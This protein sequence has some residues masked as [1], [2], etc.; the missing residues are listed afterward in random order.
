MAF[1]G[2]RRTLAVLP[3]LLGCGRAVSPGDEAR[4]ER[5]RDGAAV[6]GSLSQL[7]QAEW[8]EA[9]ARLAYLRRGQPARSYVERIRLTLRDPRSGQALQARGAVAVSPG[10]A[11]RMILLGPGGTTA[12]DM[13]VT[14]N[15]FRFVLPALKLERRGGT[16]QASWKG[17]PIGMLRWWFLSPLEGRL[18][19]GRAS[20]RESSWL[21]RDGS[22]TVTL[23]TDGH[24]FLAWRR[25]GESL[26]AIEWL[27]RRLV[28]QAGEHG[29]YLEGRSG[30]Q[31]EL[32]VEELLAT[33]PS[34]E[35]F[36]DPDVED[37]TSL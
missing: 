15:R 10:H 26:E 8:T 28:P 3:F 22:S 31:V 14:R 4:R 9:R 37:A 20:P 27:S 21:L 36:A 13:W 29:R 33:E 2:L 11:V 23:R 25:E 18:L 17:L 1:A 34:P 35:A 7:S 32:F 6:N 30:L 5:E 19:L 12:L 16:D 24:R